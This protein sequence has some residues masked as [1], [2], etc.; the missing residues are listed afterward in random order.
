MTDDEYR[1][2]IFDAALAGDV[3]AGH[4]ALRICRTCLDSNNMPS[5]LRFYLAERITEL[6]DGVPPGKALCIA[7]ERGRPKDPFP[8]W[9]QELGALAALL[10]QRGYRPQEVCV[11]M[12]DQRAALHDLSLDESDAHSIRVQWGPMQRIDSVMLVHLAGRYGEVL[13]KY[14]PRK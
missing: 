2:S 14:P 7:K 9:R 3:E 4:E 1:K 8:E 5:D 6:L 10:T 13:P 11:A 12:C